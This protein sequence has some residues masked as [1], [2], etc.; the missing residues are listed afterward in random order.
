LAGYVAA[1]FSFAIGPL[2]AVIVVGIG[3]SLALTY[4][5]DQY[6]I[7][8]RVIAG[9]DELSEGIKATIERKK[10]ALI[11][12]DHK[13]ANDVAESVIDYAIERAQ[14]VFINTMNHLFRGLTTPHI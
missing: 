2:L 6:Q 11:G 5:D 10:R 13:I 9:L 14:R 1:T 12:K 7:T 4:I 8:D 3:V